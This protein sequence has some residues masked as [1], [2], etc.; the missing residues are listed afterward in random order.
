MKSIKTNPNSAKGPDKGKIVNK[1]YCIL[2]TTLW[3]TWLYFFSKKTDMKF[4]ILVSNLT[5]KINSDS[6]YAFKYN[7]IHNIYIKNDLGIKYLLL[8]NKMVI[9][10]I[11]VNI[12]PR[13]ISYCTRKLV[14]YDVLLETI[15][16]LVQYDILLGTI[17]TNIHAIILYYTLVLL[18]S[19]G[20]QIL[21]IPI[22]QKNSHVS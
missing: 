7:K 12:V 5:K 3:L 9:A 14:Q 4:I 6:L 11:L 13:N 19:I 18:L 10:W 2:L 20:I 17:F 15:R 22:C 8:Y 1:L 16:K 21:E